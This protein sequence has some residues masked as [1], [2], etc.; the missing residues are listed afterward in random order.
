[1]GL[2]CPNSNCDK[3]KTSLLKPTKTPLYCFVIIYVY[4][5]HASWLFYTHSS[6]FYLGHS[7]AHHTFLYSRCPQMLTKFVRFIIGYQFNSRLRWWDR[8]SKITGA[9]REHSNSK[10]CC[11]VKVR[12]LKAKTQSV[13]TVNCVAFVKVSKAK[14]QSGVVL[15]Y[16]IF[17]FST[18]ATA[19]PVASGNSGQWWYHHV[20]ISK[21]NLKRHGEG[22]ERK[23]LSRQ[24]HFPHGRPISHG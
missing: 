16:F 24:I 3:T 9:G 8:E 2:L 13:E 14:T 22:N 15:V 23:E 21:L 10:L 5:M 6:K 11:L 20:A 7:H 12:L 19:R 1:M 4:K 18:Y 17:S